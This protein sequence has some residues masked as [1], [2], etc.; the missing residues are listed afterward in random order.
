MATHCKSPHSV[1]II[2]ANSDQKINEFTD[3]FDSGGRTDQN[4]HR[5]LWCHEPQNFW[6]IT[7]QTLHSTVISTRIKCIQFRHFEKIVLLKLWQLP[8]RWKY[9]GKDK[10][11]SS[12][13]GMV[14]VC[15]F[16]YSLSVQFYRN[17]LPCMCY[18]QKTHIHKTSLM[19]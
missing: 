13:S 10:T 1:M 7:L 11:L 14:S 17:W 8:G 4:R 3:W 2:L 6:N 5:R 9:W 16:C 18:Q 19:Y 12:T 15:L